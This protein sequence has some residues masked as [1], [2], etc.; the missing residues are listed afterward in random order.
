MGLIGAGSL[1]C[2]ASFNSKLG[3]QLG[4][5]K[6][7]A[8]TMAARPNTPAWRDLNSVAEGPA[9]GGEEAWGSRERFELPIELEPTLHMSIN[10]EESE[11]T[12]SVETRRKRPD[13]HVLLLCRTSCWLSL[14]NE[15]QI[16]KAPKSAEDETMNCCLKKRTERNVGRVARTCQDSALATTRTD[17]SS[18][19]L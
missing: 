16:S 7:C 6:G 12:C 18:A 8:P 10:W 19:G 15:I 2:V 14:S 13:K 5:S 3:I 11:L 9:A 17:S 4:T 1:T